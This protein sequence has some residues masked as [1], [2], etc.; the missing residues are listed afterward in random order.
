MAS[1]FLKVR[2]IDRCGPCGPAEAND[3]VDGRQLVRVLVREWTEEDVIDHAEDG[4]V[5]ADPES[6]RE[7]S[8]R[9]K[10]RILAHHAKR[11]ARV[12]NQSLEP[13]PAPH[14]AHL[15]SQVRDV[16]ELLVRRVPSI[17]G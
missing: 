5:R 6:Q 8:D 11:I 1:P 10:A 16:A 13:H 12:L 3:F 15:L 2:Q 14:L 7:N 17:I 4:R 9:R